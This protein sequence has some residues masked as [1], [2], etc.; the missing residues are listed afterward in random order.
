[1][2]ERSELRRPISEITNSLSVSDRV[3][4][5]SGYSLWRWLSGSRDTL[6]RERVS[7][8][9]LGPCV[10]RAPSLTHDSRPSRTTRKSYGPRVPDRT[11]VATFD[12]VLLCW[13]RNGQ[14]SSRRCDENRWQRKPKSLGQRVQQPSTWRG[15]SEQILLHH[16]GCEARKSP[17]VAGVFFLDFPFYRTY[18][19]LTEFVG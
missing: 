19:E 10:L 14:T 5:I 17:A 13:F 6:V 12:R 16:V 8:D 18:Q 3:R 1:M 7:A 9:K 4:S 2:E 15:S 11:M